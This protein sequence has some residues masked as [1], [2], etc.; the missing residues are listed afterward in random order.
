M[1]ESTIQ[2]Y[3]RL[4]KEQEDLYNNQA[5]AE[6]YVIKA[7]EEMEGDQEALLDAAK[8]YMRKGEAF[9]DKA[10]EY[11]RDAYSFGMQNRAV[12]L[13]YA[14]LLVQNGRCE[15]ANVIL[16]ALASTGYETA[17]VNMLLSIAAGATGPDA[18]AK[19][20]KAMAL[21]DYMRSK[22]KVPEAGTVK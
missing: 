22:G 19:K 11:L 6:E 21:I 14:C 9:A 4:S 5:R 16:R 1:G 3:K 12:A 13:M 18:L 17:K 15:E 2:R 7:C 20:Y 8:F 10:A